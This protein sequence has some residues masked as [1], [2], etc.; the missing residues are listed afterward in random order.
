MST[1]M[2]TTVMPEQLDEFAVA[3]QEFASA[4]AK[5]LHLLEEFNLSGTGYPFIRP[6]DELVDD[7]QDWA[8]ATQEDAHIKG[9]RA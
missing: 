1:T 3:V 8:E 2:E 7:L 6:L 5:V 9:G 4:A